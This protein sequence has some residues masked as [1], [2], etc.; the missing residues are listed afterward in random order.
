MRCDYVQELCD[1]DKLERV[2]WSCY[3]G[4]I[5]THIIVK[6]M[7]PDFQTYGFSDHISQFLRAEIERQLVIDLAHYGVDS[8]DLR[9]NWS[10]SFKEGHESV[11][12]ADWMESYSG[13][14]VFSTSGKLVADGWLDFVTDGE[15]LLVYW[16]VL[17]IKEGDM[18]VNVKKK[19]GI[20]P[21]IWEQIPVDVRPAYEK[22]RMKEV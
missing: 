13:M 2:Y 3:N 12:K 14:E 11:Y 20:P 18:Q 16:D 6:N 7:T 4:L 10:K 1:K 8:Q 9:F 17:D 19:F 5:L 15:L 22:N 21:H